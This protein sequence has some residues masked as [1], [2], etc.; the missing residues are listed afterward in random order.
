MA[1]T[2]TARETA[3]A[4]ADPATGAGPA[5]LPQC[6]GARPGSVGIGMEWMVLDRA[7]YDLRPT[8]R[9]LLPLLDKP[10]GTWAATAATDAATL[11]VAT[12]ML[13]GYREA[14]DQATDIWRS[15]R[16]AA[17]EAGVVVAGGGT[18]P[19][20][21]RRER[22]LLD[23]Q[24]PADPPAGF[25]MRIQ[26]GVPGGDEAVRI[27][28]WLGLRAPLFIAL[29]ASSPYWEGV[30]SGYCSARNNIVGVFQASGVM[31]AS[32]RSRHDVARH[33]ARL[34]QRGLAAGTGEVDWDVRP[35]LRHNVVEMRALDT[36]LHPSYAAA[37]A[38]YAREL[39]IEAAERPGAWPR[40]S[41]REVY[42]WNRFN[43]CRRGV[44]GD[45][46]DPCSRKKYPIEQ[47]VR[48]DLARL[49]VRSNDPDFL[50]ACVL[51]H[52]LLHNGGQARWL[53]ARMAADAGPGDLA[54]RA[55]EM[56]ARSP[57]Q[58]SKVES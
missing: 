46:I 55:G 27:C 16:R 38:C 33:V 50:N 8:A 32:L 18:Q 11:E 30:D 12:A 23:G 13:G 47:V 24:D 54:R 25:G 51:I 37:L 21:T 9:D 34:A 44:L 6:A 5:R 1:G 35:A 43:A 36:P 20:R 57:A 7:T 42:Q 14:A 45:W 29:S 19:F 28:A 40:W 49:V 3:A 2:L 17:D 39:C 10:T 26:V 31:P 22:R 53:T 56:F 15:M 52:E 41:T 58:G 4:P 48:D